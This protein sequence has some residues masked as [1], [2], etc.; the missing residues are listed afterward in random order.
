[1]R[2]LAAVLLI[3]LGSTAWAANHKFEKMS[4]QII[5]S[6][7]GPSSTS[8]AHIGSSVN[9]YFDDIALLS[10]YLE[11]NT[12]EYGSLGYYA[13]CEANCVGEVGDYKHRISIK[14]NPYEPNEIN[15][16]SVEKKKSFRDGFTDNF[17][18]TKCVSQEF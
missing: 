11:F 12:N 9:L 5:F 8:E 18:V 13:D 6:K 7:T 1:M 2:I 14:P 3:G 4:C 10:V 17:K 15:V 16:T